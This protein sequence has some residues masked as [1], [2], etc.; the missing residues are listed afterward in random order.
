M[1]GLV[2]SSSFTKWLYQF[3][4]LPTMYES[5]RHST[6]LLTLGWA[7]LSVL[8]DFPSTFFFFRNVTQFVSFPTSY[9]YSIG[10][11]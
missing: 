4:V 9:N 2:S 5:S 10:Q 3:T 8:V 11:S 1:L 6:S 7:L